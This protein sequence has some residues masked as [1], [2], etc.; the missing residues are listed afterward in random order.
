MHPSEFEKEK[1]CCNQEKNK[2]KYPSKEDQVDNETEKARIS[3]VCISYYSIENIY[4]N[5]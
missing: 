4:F 5:S 1:K 2:I 3:E